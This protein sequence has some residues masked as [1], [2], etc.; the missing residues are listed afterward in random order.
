MKRC[1]GC[2]RYGLSFLSFLWG[3]W[4]LPSFLDSLGLSCG[5]WGNLI[6]TL[7]DLSQVMFRT[8]WHMGRICCFK[9]VTDRKIKP[10]DSKEL[11]RQLSTCFRN[12]KPTWPVLNFPDVLNW[13]ASEQS[14]ALLKPSFPCCLTLITTT[15]RHVDTGLQCLATCQVCDK[16]KHTLLSYYLFAPL[17]HTLFLSVLHTG[18]IVCSIEGQ[19]DALLKVEQTVQWQVT[20]SQAAPHCCSQQIST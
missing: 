1:V 17:A 12:L 6:K 4:K 8:Q 5:V 13:K 11:Q 20:S 9:S 16:D 10:N 18:L 14:P 15:R 3:V 2:W 7:T 19:W